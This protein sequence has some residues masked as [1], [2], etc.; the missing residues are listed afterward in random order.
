MGTWKT[1]I[2]LSKDRGRS[3]KCKKA[4]RYFAY[5]PAEGWPGGAPEKNGYKPH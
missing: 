1:R 5:P 2:F 4:K 3:E